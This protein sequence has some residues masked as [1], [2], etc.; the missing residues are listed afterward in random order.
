MIKCC[1]SVFCVLSIK[2]GKDAEVQED[3][4]AVEIKNSHE[5]RETM[6]GPQ[7]VLA[8]TSSP[9]KITEKSPRAQVQNMAECPAHGT[10]AELSECTLISPKTELSTAN[11]R[12]AEPATPALDAQDRILDITTLMTQAVFAK[13][14]TEINTTTMHD[15]LA[16]PDDE[17]TSSEPVE[18]EACGQVRGITEILSQPN[19]RLPSV[20]VV[21]QEDDDS[22]LNW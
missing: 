5:V 17:D 7:K 6:N 9:K 2:H 8:E 18:A 10:H 15:K 4:K 13:N 14:Q 20:A 1:F 11:F 16:P 19:T 12:A 22:S 21:R 3:V